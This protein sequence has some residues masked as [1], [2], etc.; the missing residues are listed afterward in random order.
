MPTPPFFGVFQRKIAGLFAGNIDAGLFAEAE[1]LRIMMNAIEAEAGAEN[2][3]VL[4]VG[5]RQRLRHVVTDVAADIDGGVLADQAFGESSERG[6]ELDGRAGNE[7]GLESEPLIHHAEHAAA[8]GVHHDDAARE[9][10]KGSDG[11]A[12]DGEIVAID[13]IADGGIDGGNGGF[14]WEFL[15]R[16]GG[17]LFLF[18]RSG[19]WGCEAHKLEQTKGDERYQ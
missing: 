1:H 2:I 11:G 14:V 10:A 9:A 13:V 5:T 12:A 19:S 16:G 15:A 17:G 4:I 18:L 7:A 6:D 8:E 3:E